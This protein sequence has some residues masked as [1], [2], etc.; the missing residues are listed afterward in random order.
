[1][2]RF[3][4]LIVAVECRS[5]G[6]A[7]K[8]V[9]IASACGFRESGISSVGRR[10]I[11]GI[12]CSIR[13]EVPLGGSNGLLVSEE[14]VRFLVGI[15]NGKM[16]VNR[17]RTDLFFDKLVSSGFGGVENGVGSGDGDELECV[18]AKKIEACLGSLSES[19]EIDDG[20]MLLLFFYLAYK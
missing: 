13:L 16:E 12:R 3:E 4:P 17:K 10:V 18:E 6:D 2:F 9:S 15:A 20:G 8:L 5:V 1:M 11:V 7:H 19:Q 14:Y